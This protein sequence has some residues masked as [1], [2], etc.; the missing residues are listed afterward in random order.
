MIAQH[1][2][3]ISTLEILM[4]YLIQNLN[5]PYDCNATYG[6]TALLD[7]NEDCCEE[8][9]IDVCNVC[10]GDNSTCLTATDI[11][12]NIYATVQIGEQNWMK[13]NLKVTHYN[14]GSEISTGYTN[15][16]WT[17]IDIGGYG[18]YNDDPYNKDVYGN[19]YN[20][21]AIN[22]E[23]GVCPDGWH[24]PSN[25]EWL[26]LVNHLDEDSNYSEEY[27][28]SISQT[29]GAD[30]K[31]VGDTHWTS[32]SN[33]GNNESGFTALPGG[34]RNGNYNGTGYWQLGDGGCFLSITEFSQ[35]TSEAYFYELDYGSTV[36]QQTR[37]KPYGQ[38]VRCIQ[39]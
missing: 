34:A 11:D 39:D 38:S 7:I 13:Q 14:D 1:Q 21:Y 19:L 4:N 3:K 10:D 23:R 28:G 6:G 8:S 20:W 29:A 37:G 32:S 27:I 30:L 17:Y 24:I 9:V 36:R 16:D 2:Q 26:E 22:D 33:T 18:V 12:G 5:I 15:E 25:N 35:N 31:E